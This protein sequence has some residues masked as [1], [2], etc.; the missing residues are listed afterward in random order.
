MIDLDMEAL[1]RAWEKAM[2]SKELTDDRLRQLTV[3]R[4]VQERYRPALR[5]L[6]DQVTPENQHKDQWSDNTHSK[7]LEAAREDTK[8]LDWLEGELQ[9][10]KAWYDELNRTGVPPENARTP[11]FRLNRL[12]TRAAIDAA[13]E[14]EKG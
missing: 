5:E 2:E 1:M 7:A 11:L 6:A 12:I 14:T 10:E 9:R 13:M 3:S 4:D 8:R